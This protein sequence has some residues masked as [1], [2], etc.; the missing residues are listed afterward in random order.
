METLDIA[1]D[2]HVG[3]RGRI[4]NSIITSQLILSQARIQRGGGGALGHV[5]PQ[6][7]R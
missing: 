2:L 5:P 3:K 4:A 1:T 7:A 6:F